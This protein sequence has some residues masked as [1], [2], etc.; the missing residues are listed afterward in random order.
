MESSGNMQIHRY[1]AL[2][3]CL[4]SLNV[5]VY[6]HNTFKVAEP[7]DIDKILETVIQT[8]E[9]TEDSTDRMPLEMQK[10]FKVQ[11]ANKLVVT[12][13]NDAGAILGLYAFIA[14]NDPHIIKLEYNF[15]AAN[16]YYD[17]YQ[18]ELEEIRNTLNNKIM[19][20]AYNL[21][22]KIIISFPVAEEKSFFYRFQGRLSKL[23][24]NKLMYNIADIGFKFD[25]SGLIYGDDWHTGKKLHGWECKVINIGS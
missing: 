12:L 17:G 8:Y 2:L 22:K 23:D 21:G 24:I 25:K 18:A 16:Y 20:H 4:L 13:Q 15:I 6:A 1:I 5:T 9:V 11:I 7:K 19:Q 3:V 14:T 10:F